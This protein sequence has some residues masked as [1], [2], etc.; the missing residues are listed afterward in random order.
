M[1]ILFR[2]RLP[3][4]VEETV[5]KVVVVIAMEVAVVIAM[6]VAVIDMVVITDVVASATEM[7]AID[8]E[9]GTVS[10]DMEMGAVAK[11]MVMGTVAKDMVMGTVVMDTVIMVMPIVHTADEIKKHL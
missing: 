3:D 4:E 9:M 8:P 2:I 10:K 1:N 5:I 11:D 6:E 7:V